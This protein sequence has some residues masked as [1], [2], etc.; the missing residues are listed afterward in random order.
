M[1]RFARRLARLVRPAAW[2]AVYD[3]RYSVVVPGVPMDPDRGARILAFLFDSRLLPRRAV[4]QPQPTSMRNILRAHDPAYVQSLQDP[5][6]VAGIVGAPLSLTEAGTVLDYQRLVAGGT[7]HALRL[8]LAARRPVV[9]LAGGL[10]HAGPDRGA[11]FCVY[12]DVAVAVRRLQA[13]GFRRPVLI[14]DLDLHQGNGT[15][16]IFADDRVVHTYSI[17][18]VHWDVRPAVAATDIALGTGVE[19]ATFFEA[20]ESTLP[21]VI[22]AHRPGLVVY[23]AGTDPASDDVLGDW[24]LTPEGMLRRD[25]FVVEQVRARRGARVPFVVVLGGGYGHG[26]WRHTARFL[27]WLAKGRA[28]EP[29][30]DMVVALRRMRSAFARLP[31]RGG[32]TSDAW[33]ISNED[34]VDGQALHDGRFLG[35]FTAHGLEALLQTVGAFPRLR[36]LGFAHPTLD[37]DFGSGLGET[38]RIFGDR[39]RRHLLVEMRVRRDRRLAPGFELL[40]CE[41]LL[42]QNPRARFTEQAPALPGQQHPGLGLLGTMVA[43]LMLM[44]E[45][46]GL[47]GVATVPSHYHVAAVGREHLRFADPGVQ[48]RFESLVGLLRGLPLGDAEQALADG[49]IVDADGVVVHW[50]P[51]L[52]AIPVSARFREALTGETYE[53]VRAAARERLAYRI[54]N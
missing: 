49:R 27:A 25:R 10:H 38:L 36:A 31:E 29:P 51:S 30:D 11:G 3:E 44:A 41:W 19:D 15:R 45:Q 7:I 48:A 28:L 37:L 16:A 5:A 33:R 23:V 9:H 14:V 50:E 17:H 21:G 53:A 26:A 1:R 22:D 46:L 52:M 43:M 20:L 13:K 54:R 6:V 34:L 39:Q 4:H 35:R 42:L 18:N 12:N 2:H 24:R 40:F 8:A 47:D 32:R